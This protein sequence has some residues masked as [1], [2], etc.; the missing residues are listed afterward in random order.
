MEDIEARSKHVFGLVV[1][2]GGKIFEDRCRSAE[3]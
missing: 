1:R 2:G 3:A